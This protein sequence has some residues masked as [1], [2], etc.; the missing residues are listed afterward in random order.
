MKLFD[1]IMLAKQGVGPKSGVL[2]PQAPLKRPDS[3]N[4]T[5]NRLKM[6]KTDMFL[7][8]WFSYSTPTSQHPITATERISRTRLDTSLH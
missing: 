4:Q 1:D 7:K 5:Q 8:I 6:I 3:F 2:I